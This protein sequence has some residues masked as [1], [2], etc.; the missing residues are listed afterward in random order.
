MYILSSELGRPIRNEQYTDN[1]IKKAV[2]FVVVVV[3]KERREHHRP[4]T[5]VLHGTWDADI[6]VMNNRTDNKLKK[7]AGARIVAVVADKSADKHEKG[8]KM[9]FEAQ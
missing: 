4:I 3:L 9:F 8:K 5:Y 1:T 6:Y 7:K 2:A